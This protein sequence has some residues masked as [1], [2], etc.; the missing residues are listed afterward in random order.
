LN[1]GLAL[2]VAAEAEPVRTEVVIG[3]PAREGILG[4]GPELFDFGSDSVI[5]L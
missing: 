5:V 4:F 1:A 3:D 2:A